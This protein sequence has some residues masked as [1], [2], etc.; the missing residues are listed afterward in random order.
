MEAIFA[1]DINGGLSKNG[2]IPWTSKTDMTFFYKK[3]CN[4]IVIMGKTTFFSLSKPLKNRLNI[5]L[6][7]EKANAPLDPSYNNVIFTDNDKVYEDIYANRAKYCEKY[8]F[9]SREFKIYII[10]GA[11]IYRRFVPLCEKVWVTRI[12]KDYACDLFYNFDGNP[13]NR[14]LV[15]DDDEL[16][17]MG[18]DLLLIKS[19]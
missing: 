3:T 15:Y 1:T 6:T 7:R 8:S 12:K 13:T 10:G 19:V 9:L 16:V 4:H 2:Q 18:Y 14:E 17:I 5:V 11:Q